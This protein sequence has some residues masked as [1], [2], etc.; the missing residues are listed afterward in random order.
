MTSE[1]TLTADVSDFLRRADDLVTR[2]LPIIEVWA[3]NWTAYDAQAALKSRM[4]V[5]FDRPTTWTLNAFHVWRARKSSPFATV[6]PRPSMD[7]RHYLRVQNAGGARPQTA[8]EK[9]MSHRVVTDQILRSVLPA[10]G[11]RLNAYGNW[12]P[13]ERNQALSE[14]GAQRQDMRR[15]ASANATSASIARARKRGRDKYFVPKNGG[16]APGIWKRNARGDLSQVVFF[17]D[18]APVYQPVLDFEGVVTKAYRER[19]APNLQR[20]FDRAL[21]NPR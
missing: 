19:L 7:S 16:L 9:L 10:D 11:A 18:K 12:S 17:S 8:L 2:Q 13:G 1:M 14:I 4:Q 6:A 15:G 21:S 5:V 20:A 3:V